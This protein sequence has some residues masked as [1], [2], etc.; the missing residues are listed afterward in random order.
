[1]FTAGLALV[2]ALAFSSHAAAQQPACLA[3]IPTQTIT[4]VDQANVRPRA[5]AKVEGAVTD[6]SLQLR[7][8]WG[9]PCVKFGTGGHL[10]YLQT[11]YEAD[12][13]GGYTMTIGGDHYGLAVPGPNWQGQPYASVKTGA[14]TYESWSYAFSHEITEMLV[15]PNDA[16]YHYWPNGTRQLLEVCDPVENFTYSLGG[17][18]VEDFTL[19]AAWSGAPSGPYDEA[20]KL[21]AP[22]TPG[23]TLGL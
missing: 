17:V 5:L 4:V 22:L 9:T 8:A 14:A 23:S 6:Q 3:G 11:G 2:A 10:V 19:P 13:G 12:P 18:S 16:T 21:A 7:A 15:D 20:G 1:M